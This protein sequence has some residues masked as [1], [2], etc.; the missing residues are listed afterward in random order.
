MTDAVY[1]ERAALIAHLAA[2]YPAVIVRN[3]DPADDPD[4]PLIY[5]DT[6][7]G[8]MSWHLTQADLDLFPH[9]PTV[10]E[11]PEWDGHTNGEKYRRLAA[12][13][14]D[15]AASHGALLRSAHSDPQFV[16]PG[17]TL[18]LRSKA[19]MTAEVAASL[20]AAVARHLPGVDAL[21]LGNFEQMA[22]YQPDQHRHE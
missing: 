12:L 13:T 6:P 7:Q 3:G 14:A 5:I 9:V 4:W 18:I 11:G 8:Q 19:L 1:R 10:A 15:E 2:L 16:R 20:K 22:V 17:D 21:V